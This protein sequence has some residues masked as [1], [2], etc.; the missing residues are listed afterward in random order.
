M[1][2]AV[3]ER[4]GCAGAREVEQPRPAAGEVLVQVAVCGV[5]GTDVHIMHG[6]FRA[7]YPVI[8]GHEFC[9]VVTALGPG[10]SGL[11]PGDRVVI[12][13]N[14]VCGRCPYCRRGLVHLCTDLRAV[15]VTQP[16]GFASFVAL[17]AGQ[18][19]RLPDAVDDE[20]AAFTEPLACCLHGLDRAEIRAGDQVAILGAG[21][22]GLLMLQL[23]RLAGA[24]H[25]TVSEP[26]AAKRGLAAQL[27]ADQ[28]LDPATD[29]LRAAVL[30][31]NGIGA[32]VVIECVGGAAPTAQAL[33]LARRGGRVV[34]FGVSP[35]EAEVAL[36][37]YDVFLNELTILG[38]YINPFTHARAIELLAGGRVKTAPLVSHRLGLEEFAA[39]LEIAGEGAAAKVLVRP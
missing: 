23:A 11:E 22:I 32:D 30:D 34:L 20:S 25:I 21:P 4:P 28:G 1:R 37:P 15:G 12:D 36:R 13:P 35:H 33:T 16:G 10:V 7:Q 31:H 18:A 2:A 26:Q 38:S 14:I 5:C 19:H 6:G 24:A 9:G 29:D 27:G 17:P 3:I 39:A 8:P